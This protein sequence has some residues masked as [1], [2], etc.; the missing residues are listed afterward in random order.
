MRRICT[1]LCVGLAGLSLLAS[2]AFAKSS[3]AQLIVKDLAATTPARQCLRWKE[4]R[5]EAHP[6]VALNHGG[7]GAKG[8]FQYMDS[9]WRYVLSRAE[10]YY[11]V[12]ISRATNARDASAWAQNVVTAFA[13]RHPGRLD[14]RPWPY[15]Y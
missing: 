5:G 11:G 1:A 13:V 10:A 8:A 14:H 9:T 4:T 15:C 2:N 12:D 7:S 6:Y 3:R